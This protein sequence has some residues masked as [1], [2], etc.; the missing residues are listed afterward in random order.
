M[1]ESGKGLFTN[2]IYWFSHPFTQEGDVKNWALFA[3]LV[4]IALWWWYHIL[5]HIVSGE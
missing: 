1:E 3:I 4:A 5:S 2:V